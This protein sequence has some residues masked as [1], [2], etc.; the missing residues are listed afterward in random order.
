MKL[1]KEGTGIVYFGYSTCP[2]CRNSVPILIDV[3]K[4]N[5][6]KVIYYYDIH[7]ENLDSI[8]KELYEILDPYLREKE[9]G[10]KDLSVPDVYAIKKG[11]I[12][13]HHIGTV[14]SYKNPTK[15]MNK[16]QKKELEDIYDSLIKEVK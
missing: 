5:K 15:G 4:K 11:K 2:W 12:K 10:K 3:A 16:K 9:D 14:S 7:E 6:L 8:K 1:F 13:G